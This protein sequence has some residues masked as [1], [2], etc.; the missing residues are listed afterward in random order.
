MNSNN[1]GMMIIQCACCLI[2]SR[3]GVWTDGCANERRADGHDG[4]DDV[5][6]NRST[7]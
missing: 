6:Q 2:L 7:Y 4:A 5:D 3:V 1:L